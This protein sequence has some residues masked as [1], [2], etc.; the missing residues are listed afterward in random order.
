MGTS[1]GRVRITTLR[2][3]HIK[4]TV[5]DGNKYSKIHSTLKT[6][7]YIW[8][9]RCDSRYELKILRIMSYV[10]YSYFYDTYN[11]DADP[12]T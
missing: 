8:F 6:A 4:I 9:P 2:K 7:L 3:L 10:G 5:D 12:L 11:Q 1:E